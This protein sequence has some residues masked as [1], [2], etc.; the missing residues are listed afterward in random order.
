MQFAWSNYVGVELVDIAGG[1]TSIAALA[2][3]CKVWRPRDHWADARVASAFV[4]APSAFAPAPIE[5]HSAGAS[6]RHARTESTAVVRAWVPWVFLSI[7]VIIWGLA[8]VKRTLN[9]GALAPSW[10]VP[11]LHRAVFRDYPV[12]P[13]PV[14][15]APSPN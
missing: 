10:D 6:A 11:M 3:F 12:V 9:Q 7:A 14:E 15:N 5:T 8:P 4:T 2:W 13:Q 1:L